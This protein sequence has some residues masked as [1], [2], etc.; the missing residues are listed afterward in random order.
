MINQNFVIVGFILNLIGGA[1]YFIDTIK[2]KI[3]PNRVTWFL[4]GLAPLIAFAAEV[5]EGVGLQSLM[6]LGVGLTPVFIFIAS[7]Y[8]KKSVWKLKPFDFLCGALSLVGLLL[9]Y[10][11]KIGT[12]A[13]V[14]SIIADAMAS[15]PTIVKSYTT[16]K[17]ENYVEYLFAFFSAALTVLTIRTWNFA[18]YG[19]PIYMIL[20]NA[21]CFVLIKFQLGKRQK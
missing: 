10:L 3:Q 15:I 21:L 6:T 1:S 4:W 17:S 11:T 2:G 9:W 12:I 19:F 5:Q 8:N 20:I 18:T 13:I 14:F 16:P 7:F